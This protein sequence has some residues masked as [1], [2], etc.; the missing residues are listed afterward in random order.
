VTTRNH[1]DAIIRRYRQRNLG[2]ALRELQRFERMSLKD[3]VLHAGL[4]EWFDER[5]N[6]WMRFDHQ[7]RIPRSRLKAAAKRLRSVPLRNAKS[8]HDLFLMVESTIGDMPRI[9]ELMIY[10]SALRIGAN[11]GLEPMYVY[12]HRGTRD[13]ARELGLN[14]RARWLKRHELPPS[15]RLLPAWQ[16]EDILCIFKGWLTGRPKSSANCH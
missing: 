5:R 1:F 9:G 10:D 2:K 4:A 15:F 16:V 11:L 12:L 14:F 8:F 3:A 13:G 7:R 6:R